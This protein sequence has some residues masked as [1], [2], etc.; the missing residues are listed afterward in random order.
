MNVQDYIVIDPTVLARK[1]I[2]RGTLLSVE[3]VVQLL[4]QGWNETDLQQ[5]YPGI[6]HEQIA[7]CRQYAAGVLGTK[8]YERSD[9]PRK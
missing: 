5:N 2:I 3:F 1:P 6:T 4:A 8:K 7:A 9:R